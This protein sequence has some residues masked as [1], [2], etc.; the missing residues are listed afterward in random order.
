MWVHTV[1][2]GKGEELNEGRKHL[3]REK[4]FALN[5][6]IHVKHSRKIKKEDGKEFVWTPRFE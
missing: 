1:V 2:S 3:K 4:I 6:E 5:H